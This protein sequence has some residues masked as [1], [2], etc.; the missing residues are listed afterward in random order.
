VLVDLLQRQASLTAEAEELQIKKAFM[1][2]DEYAREF[3]RVMLALARI[4]REVRDRT[5]S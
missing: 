4:G 5:K 2:A 1:S 3:E